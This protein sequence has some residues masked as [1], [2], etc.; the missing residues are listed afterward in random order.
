MNKF[1]VGDK[2]RRLGAG[3][4]NGSVRPG[5]IVTIAYYTGSGTL[6]VLE[7]TARVSHSEKY[8]ELVESTSKNTILMASLTSKFALAFKGEPEKSFIKAGV[9][10]EKEQ[11]TTEGRQ[12][13]EQWLLKKYGNDFKKEVI[14]PILAEDAKS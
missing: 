12:V 4:S 9:L 11:F 14:D 2:V 5:D 13:F 8:Y 10:D 1:N 3:G 7:D 6:R